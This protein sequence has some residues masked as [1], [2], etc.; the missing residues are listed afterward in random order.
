VSPNEDR[1][2]KLTESQIHSAVADFRIF[3]TRL[4]EIGF[5]HS[6]HDFQVCT[7]EIEFDVVEFLKEL[8]EDPQIQLGYDTT[9]KELI[10]TSE[11]NLTL[12]SF[13]KDLDENIAR[14]IAKSKTSMETDI[15]YY[16]STVQQIA[17]I[18]I[19]RMSKRDELKRWSE[20]V[21]PGLIRN[22]IGDVKR[23]IDVASTNSRATIGELI[24]QR[25][26]SLPTSFYVEYSASQLNFQLPNL[27]I[28]QISNE[29]E[30]RVNAV[31]AN[32]GTSVG[33]GG[34]ATGASLGGLLL[35]PIGFLAGG[36]I[37]G[38]IVEKF[39]IL[40]TSDRNKFKEVVAESLSIIK[41]KALGQIRDCLA[42][43]SQN[44]KL[45][46]EKLLADAVAEHSKEIEAEKSQ[47][48]DCAAIKE[49]AKRD[50]QILIN[51]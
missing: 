36:V 13:R 4:R 30:I 42:K 40:T 12:S 10:S 23:C 25:F 48:P 44:T 47:R 34:A 33:L 38:V 11:L 28:P 45:L 24:D 17:S 6:F 31:I 21:L 29:S 22:Y 50:L 1:V 15:N 14:C 9:Q 39:S 16:Y 35:G 51:G 20:Q 46:I 19:D 7:H 3:L 41:G 2:F 8:C 37:G 32:L 18:A 5:E 49:K 43:W 27:D 26:I